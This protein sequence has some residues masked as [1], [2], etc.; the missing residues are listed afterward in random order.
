MDMTSA[1]AI[2][3]IE[4]DPRVAG[5]IVE[6]LELEGYLVEL[7]REGAAALDRLLVGAWDGVLCDVSLPGLDGATLYR[8]LEASRPELLAR[9][10]F[11]SGHDPLE[12][13]R[14][15]QATPARTLKKPFG[16]DELRAFVADLLQPA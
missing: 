3:V 15:L 8:Q 12:V 7:A 1:K 13:A 4:D 6:I 5:F 14:R 9:T 2:L 16:I 10:A 11:I